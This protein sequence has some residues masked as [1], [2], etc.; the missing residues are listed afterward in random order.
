MVLVWLKNVKGINFIEL[1]E[2]FRLENHEYIF[3]KRNIFLV[4][5]VASITLKQLKFWQKQ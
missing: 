4:L 3:L 5:N 2:S 1:Q